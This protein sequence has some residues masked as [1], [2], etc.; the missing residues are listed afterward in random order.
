MD[1]WTI[2]YVLLWIIVLVE[3]AVLII[4]LRT[5]GSFYLN[6]RSGVNRDGLSL[7]TRAPSFS[8]PSVAGASVRI[9]ATDGRWR[10]LFSVTA[11]CEECYAAMRPLADL[12][13]D[14]DDQLR[15]VML[16]PVVANELPDMPL[17]RDTPIDVAIVG[18][19]GLRRAYRIRVLPFVHVLDP[20][21]VV[22][23]KGVMHN[24]ER[25]EHLLGEAGMQHPLLGRHSDRHR[26]DEHH[27]EEVHAHG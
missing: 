9:P 5:F 12:Q 18:H 22:R 17:L 26:T 20:A 10:A 16:L 19:E 27:Q 3:G 24:R 4:L 14:L 1:P 8:A 2:S 15:V 23:A 13:A 6:S 11:A 21:G 25:L 7:G